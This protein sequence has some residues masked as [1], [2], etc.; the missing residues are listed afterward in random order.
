MQSM[1]LERLDLRYEF[2]MLEDILIVLRANSQCAGS[3]S[4]SV[5]SFVNVSFSLVSH[6]TCIVLIRVD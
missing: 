5:S 1:D 6:M 4:F 3:I 2:D